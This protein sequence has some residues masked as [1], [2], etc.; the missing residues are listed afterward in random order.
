MRVVQFEEAIVCRPCGAD[1]PRNVSAQAL[2][3]FCPKRAWLITASRHHVGF[4][5]EV[6]LD[7]ETATCQR[8]ERQRILASSS[9]HE[10]VKSRARP[11]VGVTDPRRLQNHIRNNV[12][13]STSDKTSDEHAKYTAIIGPIIQLQIW[14]RDLEQM[15]VKS[16]VKPERSEELKAKLLDI[17]SSKDGYSKEGLYAVMAAVKIHLNLSGHASYEQTID[18][19]RQVGETEINANGL[20]YPV[21]DEDFLLLKQNTSV[22]IINT[23]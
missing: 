15:P 14:S 22:V 4:C 10:L 2:E 21:E 12:L 6:L 11:D 7:S 8:L 23:N 13:L 16:P 18:D 1:Q 17:K 20:G 9:C 19:Q 5:S 3:R